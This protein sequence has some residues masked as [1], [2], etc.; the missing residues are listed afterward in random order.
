MVNRL[1]KSLEKLWKDKCTIIIQKDVTDPET[2]ITSFEESSVLKE[3][4]CRL[5]YKTLAT[6]SDG[7]AAAVTQSV[8]LF[9][10]PEVE[11]PPSSKIVVTHEGRMLEFGQSGEPAVYSSHQEIPLE[12]WKGWA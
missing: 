5:S 2:F 10:A 12:L 4:R 8:R 7:L 11:V 9:L 1:R 3:Q 6:A